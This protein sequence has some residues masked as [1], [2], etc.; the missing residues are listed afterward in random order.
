MTKP[1]PIVDEIILRC[2]QVLIRRA[3]M[4]LTATPEATRAALLTDAKLLGR[5]LTHVSRWE[6]AGRMAAIST[7]FVKALRAS[8]HQWE[9]VVVVPRGMA[10][11]KYAAPPITAER[12]PSAAA[13]A[14]S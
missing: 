12:L 7:A 9:H 11:P 8:A 2:C 10:K 6:C 14:D 13:A 4:H 5:L 3:N 1:G